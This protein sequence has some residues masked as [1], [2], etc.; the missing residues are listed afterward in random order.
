M[1]GGGRIYFCT[2]VVLSMQASKQAKYFLLACLY[3]LFML[4][5]SPS[6]QASKQNTSPSKQ[7]RCA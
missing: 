4:Y 2:A 6:K 5:T 7:A 3:I 1:T